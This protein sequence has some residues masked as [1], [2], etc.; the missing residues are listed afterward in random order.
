MREVSAV[1]DAEVK[2]GAE[3]RR[4]G[5]SRDKNVPATQ[6]SGTQMSLETYMVSPKGKD[7]EGSPQKSKSYPRIL[8]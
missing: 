1:V 4:L 8:R 3:A 6:A 5:P 7:Y 2:S